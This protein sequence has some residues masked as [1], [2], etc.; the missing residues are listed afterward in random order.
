MG[1]EM[2]TPAKWL[3]LFC[4]QTPDKCPVAEVGQNPRLFWGRLDELPYGQSRRSRAKRVT[5]ATIWE[6]PGLP[7]SYIMEMRGAYFADGLPEAD[8]AFLLWQWDDGEAAVPV[9]ELGR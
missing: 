7:D 8:T 2:M 4:G 3:K 1:S 6:W 5:S 9:A